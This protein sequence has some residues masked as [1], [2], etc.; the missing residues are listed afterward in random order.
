MESKTSST[1]NK[2]KRQRHDDRVTL[3]VETLQ[4]MDAWIE[5][6]KAAT[7]GVAVSRKDLVNW[8]V[9]Q[10]DSHLSPDEL[11]ALRSKFFDEVRFL[12]QTIREVKAAR[13]QRRGSKPCGAL[14]WC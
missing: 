1:I 7:K 6:V 9:R 12:Q 11:A 5:Q 10:H 13:Q 4:R 14:S 8:M 3:D 2:T